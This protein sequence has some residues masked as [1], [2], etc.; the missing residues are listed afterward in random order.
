MAPSEPPF[1]P[2]PSRRVAAILIAF[3]VF[4]AVAVFALTTLSERVHEAAPSPPTR[5]PSV[6]LTGVDLS[7]IPEGWTELPAPPEIRTGAAQVWTGSQLLIWGGWFGG[8]DEQ[9]PERDGVAFDAS[10]NTWGAIPPAPIP[11]RS[12]PASAW[13]GNELLVWGG[14]DGSYSGEEPGTDRK[15]TRL[16]SS[17][18]RIS[19]AVFC[20][21]KKKKKKKKNY[22]SKKKKIKN[23]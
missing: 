19:Y 7:S 17:H 2:P 20:L 3:A 12:F 11:G 13:T 6:S 4:A 21:K 9:S 1:G 18:V 14:W 10:S 15:S 22:Y 8:S 5:A 16:N 23:K